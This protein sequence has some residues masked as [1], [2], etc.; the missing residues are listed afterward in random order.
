[1]KKPYIPKGKAAPFLALI[2][3]DQTREYTSR[4]AAEIMECDHRAVGQFLEHPMRHG[5]VFSRSNGRLRFWRGQ[6]YREGQVRGE[7]ETP[8]ETRVR[9]GTL[10]TVQPR[11]GWVTSAD[12]VR[13]QKVVPGW[14]P[15]KMV[16]VRGV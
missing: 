11:A 12:D 6:P 3:K 2:E 8:N 15:P 9:I 1:M 14:T 5:L 10:S 16:C 4:E 7:P 13:Y